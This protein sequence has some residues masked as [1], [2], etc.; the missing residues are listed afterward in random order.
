[1]LGKGAYKIVWKAIDLE[2]GIEVAWNSF[3]VRDGKPVRRGILGEYKSSCRISQGIP[4]SCDDK[5][6]HLI[7]PVV[8]EVI[9][10]LIFH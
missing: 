9:G 1:M 3:Q 8:C 6:A 4:Q 5:L 10:L 2:D 7:H